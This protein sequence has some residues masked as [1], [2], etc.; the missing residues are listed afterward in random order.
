MENHRA[1]I[2]FAALLVWGM[3]TFGIA[4]E[5][6][7]HML[8]TD[9]TMQEYEARHGDTF[10]NDEIE[11]IKQGSSDEDDGTRPLQHFFDPVHD[12]GLT[13]APKS[14]LSSK[15]WMRDTEAQGNYCTWGFCPKRIRQNDTHFS[16]ETDFS[17]ER[18]VYEYAHGDKER[19]LKTLGHVLHL[20][21]DA[22]V[23]AH[24]RND[25]HLNHNGFGDP[26]PYEK[27]SAIVDSVSVTGKIPV[28]SNIEGAVNSAATFT[29]NNFLSKDT[30]FRRYELPSLNILHIR[31]GFVYHPEFGHKLARIER[32][33]KFAG[34]VKDADVFI[35]DP[36]NSVASDYWNMLSGKAIESGAGVID[37]FFREVEK[38]K[39]TLTLKEKNTSEAE[40]NSKHLA[41]AGFKFV[42]GLYG[43]SLEQE[44]VEELVNGNRNAGQGSTA[45]LA[46]ESAVQGSGQEEDAGSEE[47]TD[48][49]VIG[50]LVP[51]EIQPNDSNEEQ[52]NTPAPEAPAE[53]GDGSF[54]LASDDSSGEEPPAAAPLAPSPFELGGYAYGA[55]GGGGIGST[56]TVSADS[57]STDGADDTDNADDTNDADDADD[58]EEDVEIADT[59]APPAPTITSPALLPIVVATT[60]VTVSGTAEEDSTVVLT[61]P[62]F[63]GGAL[64]LSAIAT[65]G[66]WSFSVELPEGINI[67]ALSAEDVAGNVSDETS[68]SITVNMN[69]SAPFVESPLDGA[70]F[71]TTTV[72]V[73]GT[74]TAG[75][76]VTVD[77]GGSS[78]TTTAGSTGDWNVPLTLAEG[79]TDIIVYGEDADG[80]ASPSVA[81]TV[82]VDLTPPEAAAL[83]AVSECAYSLAVSADTCLL[84]NPLV[85][86]SW[87]VVVGASHYGITVDGA[88]V[89]TTTATSTTVTVGENATSTIAVVS[90]DAA[91]N[92]TLSDSVEVMVLSR[93]LVIHEVAWAGTDF[94]GEDE[95]IELRNVSAY[96]IDLSHLVLYT[97]DGAPHIVLSGTI[98]ADDPATLDDLYLIER[99][100]GSATNASEDIVIDFEALADSGEEL[101]LAHAHGTGTSTIDQTPAVATCGAWCAGSDTMAISHAVF[102]E[103]TTTV[104]ITMERTDTVAD[105][106]L[107]GSWQ[108]ND[109]YTTSGSDAGSGK[110]YGTPGTNNSKGYPSAG[111]FCGNDTP[112]I[113]GETYTPTAEDCTFLSAFI[114]GGGGG[115]KRWGSIY[116]GSVGSGTIEWGPNAFGKGIKHMQ[117][118]DGLLD[119]TSGTYFIALF[120]NR[121]FGNDL[122]A[123]AAYFEGTALTPP[124]ENYKVIEW[125]YGSHP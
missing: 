103:A 36:Q 13:I 88:E 85:N 98:G 68:G 57:D 1:L 30:V 21:Q 9:A 91:G 117:A 3:P 26:D 120:E 59:D 60:T 55:G 46:L 102:P 32:T 41:L 95:W 69:P 22:T 79:E 75:H 67:I 119:W 101:I 54:S 92:S 87:D 70:V 6:H 47:E 8:L 2:L 5:R 35:D 121:T 42:K 64:T 84:V 31:S 27:H 14:W 11:L 125:T 76:L 15:V 123:F 112:L 97:I 19:A 73:V 53:N 61:Y 58:A 25:Q 80:R 104:K 114:T 45:I 78:A 4:Y 124:H 51:T 90:Y 113:G 10:T 7:T 77:Y 12:R 65:G 52:A 110:I 50:V 48:V 63:G 83:V 108:N 72:A 89:A 38:E 43:S 100:N 18:A 37:L 107:L 82:S 93:P 23:P 94:S 28:F 39:Q 106:A 20:V 111:W 71:A 86:V 122:S 99:G 105:G 66:L 49:S 74:T 116:S 33:E 16:S 96:D 118:V 29:N 24:V 81:R 34:V 115:V 17:W 62:K 56:Q 40:R 109:T 44:D